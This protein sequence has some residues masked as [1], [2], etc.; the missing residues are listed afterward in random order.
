[1]LRHCVVGFSTPAAECMSESV[2]FSPD[3]VLRREAAAPRARAPLTMLLLVALGIVLSLT[4]VTTE[5]AEITS[6]KPAAPL[7]NY[8]RISLPPEH[9]PYFL[10]NNKRVAKLCHLDPLCPFKVRHGPCSCNYSFF[11]C[12]VSF[13]FFC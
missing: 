13:L 8:S 11:V 10:H 5:K 6:N 9:V 3:R 4:A 7:L 1:M 12:I 2:I